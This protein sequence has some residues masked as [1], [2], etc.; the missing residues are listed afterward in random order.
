MTLQ[1]LFFCLCGFLLLMGCGSPADNN[2]PK[3][4]PDYLVIQGQTM[5]TTYNI[6]FR[7]ADGS[8][9]SWKAR[10][11]STL[12]AI[13]MDVSTYID[14]SAISRFNRSGDPFPLADAKSNLDAFLQ[15][16]NT[17]GIPHP[18]FLANVLKAGDI[19]RQSAGNF[20]PTVMPLV[21]YWGFGTEKRPV[22]A[23]DSTRVDS[24]KQ[25]VGFGRVQVDNSTDGPVLLR[26]EL[27]GVQLDFS[28]SAKGYA[29]D[30]LSRLLEGDGLEDYYI[31]IGGEVRLKG[32]SKW[33]KPWRAGISRPQIDARPNEFVAIL[34]LDKGALASS[35]N[36]RNFYRS[37]GRIYGHTINPITGFPE[38]NSL[39]GVSVLADDCLTADAFATSFMVM[40]LDSAFALASRTPAVEA[41]FIYGDA[42]GGLA[43]KYTPGFE[44]MIQK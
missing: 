34:N 17:D 9:A 31:E 6:S 27:P 15:G 37:G 2:L 41:F 36:Y 40:G 42:D 19:H 7:Q 16:G 26:K 12:L 39:L 3:A 20:D 14:S 21:Q 8:T 29:I 24:L 1:Q 22:Q 25:F 30:E 18:H 5:G 44:Q 38:M 10:I 13:N 32:N 33:G 28:A 4:S 43:N 35:G 23:I 11:D